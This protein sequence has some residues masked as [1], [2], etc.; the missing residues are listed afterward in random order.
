MDGLTRSLALELGRHGS[1]VNSVAPGW[2][3]HPDACIR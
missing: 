2:I 1:T 3:A